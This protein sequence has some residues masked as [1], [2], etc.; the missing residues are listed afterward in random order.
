MKKSKF[1]ELL[2]QK[3]LSRSFIIGD[4]KFKNQIVYN[5]NYIK[6][7]PE[8]IKSDNVIIIDY[9]PKTIEE[10]GEMYSFIYKVDK[11]YQNI[12]ILSTE[13]IVTF[14]AKD[15]IEVPLYNYMQ[16]IIIEG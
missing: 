7:S 2:N 11:E 8:R 12:L 5:W 13:E 6:N 9:N 3:L 10:I 1:Y 15:T 14:I 16:V 4:F